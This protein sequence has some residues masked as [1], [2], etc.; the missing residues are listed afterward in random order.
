MVTWAGLLVCLGL[1]TAHLNFPFAVTAIVG[2]PDTYMMSGPS[3]GA[4]LEGKI[5]PGHRVVVLG[6]KDVW[7]KVLWNGKEVYIKESNLLPVIL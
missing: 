6:K 7:T 5:G 1:L 4:S 2:Q 3:S